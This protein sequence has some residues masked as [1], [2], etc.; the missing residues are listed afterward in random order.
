MKS[1]PS[2]NIR[3]PDVAS[4]NILNA[5]LEE[6]IPIQARQDKKRTAEARIEELEKELRREREALRKEK[7]SRARMRRYVRQG[8][9]FLAAE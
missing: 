2:L 3:A 5:P 6:G 9:S 4:P 7:E 8:L 1:D